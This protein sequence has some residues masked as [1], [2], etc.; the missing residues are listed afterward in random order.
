MTATQTQPVVP[1]FDDEETGRKLAII[2]S[3]GTLDMAY[4]GLV[5]GNA[6]LG[7]LWHAPPADAAAAAGSAVAS[8]AG[9]RTARP[10]ADATNAVREA[11]I[12]QKYEARALLDAAAKPPRPSLHLAA[13][14]DDAP[15][16]AACLIHGGGVSVL[17]L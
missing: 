10:P 13:L 4:P 2:I 12:R 5:L 3:K 9:A 7:D 17:R 1:S 11:Y 15:L 6:A 14:H 8:P 16:A